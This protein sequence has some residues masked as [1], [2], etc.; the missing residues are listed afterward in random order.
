MQ[1]VPEP[2][3]MDDEHQA[4]AYARA[5][6]SVSDQWFVDH[7]SAEFPGYLARVVDLGCGPAGVLIRLASAVP[8]VHV[9]GVDGSEPMLRLGRQAVHDAG[10]DAQVTLVQGLLPG[11]PIE[12]HAFDAVI[13]KDLLHHLHDPAV[14]WAEAR[15]LGRPGAAVYVMDLFRPPTLEAARAMTHAVVSRE[16]PV[17][18][19]DFYNSLLAAFTAD[20]VR[21]QL[22]AAGLPLTVEQVSARHMVIKGLL[23]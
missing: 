14:L 17:L 9:T 10:R 19:Q 4:V 2:E 1:R 15:R 5:D 8:T 21:D 20:E 6:F 22:R 18:Q 7:L 3:L 23:P 13:S 12:P 16:D 11:L